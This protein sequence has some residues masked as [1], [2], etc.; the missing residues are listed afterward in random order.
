M[1]TKI[2][3]G[4]KGTTRARSLTEEQREAK[5]ARDRERRA[6]RRAQAE[7]ASA[8]AARMCEG[9]PRVEAKTA[10]E[11]LADSDDARAVEV[12]AKIAATGT[13]EVSDT[14][15]GGM[16]AAYRPSPR[17]EPLT[18]GKRLGAWLTARRQLKAL[19]REHRA[20]A[21]PKSSPADQQ[22]RQRYRD[23]RVAVLARPPAVSQ[24][25]APET[26]A[27]R[28]ARHRMLDAVLTEG[29]PHAQ[30]MRKRPSSGQTGR[31]LVMR[32]PADV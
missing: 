7:A 10:D 23:E 31:G 19:V 32:R 29:G 24:G 15:N 6:E 26:W 27:E 8:N 17:S 13:I 4:G 2:I 14:P 22:S 1:K 30:P 9:D 28:K 16:V 3:K 25:D 21:L 5:N 12:T 20:K 18:P 11:I